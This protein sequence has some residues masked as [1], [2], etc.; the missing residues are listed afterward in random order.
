[1]KENY[2]TDK[3]CE[4]LNIGKSHLSTIPFEKLEKK[5]KKCN[6]KLIKKYK[7]KGKVFYEIEEFQEKQLEEL[8]EYIIKN[9]HG[10]MD[11]TGFYKN[12]KGIEWEKNVN[13][14]VKFKYDSICGEIKIL[15]YNKNNRHLKI[16]CNNET[17]EIH[18]NDFKNGK[19]AIVLKVVNK[20]F[21]FE[22]NQE[23]KTNNKH[24]II[25]D[26]R[27]T[28]GVREYRYKCLKCGFDGINCYDIKHKKM[29]EE[30]WANEYSLIDGG[31]PCCS[32]VPSFVSKEINSIYA[33]DKWMFDMLKNKEDGYIYTKSSSNKLLFK[34]PDCGKEKICT[35][36]SVYKYKSICC[37]NCSDGLSYG[38][39]YMSNLLYQLLGNEYIWQ[40]SKTNAIWCNNYRYDFYFEH[41]N[42]KYIIEINGEQHRRNTGFAKTIEE[43]KE[44]DRQ[45]KELAL[46]NGIKPKNYIVINYESMLKETFSL[47]ILHSRLDEIFNLSNINW[48]ECEIHACKNIIKEVCD[49]W[50]QEKENV[51]IE[52]LSKVFKLCK[53][54]I[55]KYLKKGTKLGWCKYDP[56]EE[57]S[58]NGFRNGKK[59]MK[60]IEVFDK[61]MNSLGIFESARYLQ[62][63]GNE[64]FG[65]N[66]TNQ[67]ISLVCNGK[68]HYHRDLIFRFYEE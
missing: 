37:P 31:C 35:P 52:A 47:N 16:L 1:M 40:F 60:P 22:I 36:C 54:T 28:E 27:K 4:L 13:K 12:W 33:T 30:Y 11:F 21:R 20:D 14:I 65:V 7:I 18:V 9:K 56:K 19:L 39:K 50:E 6:Y 58:K 42:E 43:Q 25:L 32:K 34:C 15:E 3:M 55:A 41:D 2:N 17:H 26:R 8:E 29:I 23:I 59:S 44:I 24:F 48:L 68:R 10:Y 49:Y 57:I 51:S 45:K 62:E 53:T 5:L 46:L 67:K 38:E 66:L 61:D 63:H 64:L